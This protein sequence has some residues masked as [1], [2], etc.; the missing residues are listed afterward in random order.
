MRTLGQNGRVKRGVSFCLLGQKASS[1]HSIISS[2]RARFTDMSSDDANNKLESD[3]N[4]CPT[5]SDNEDKNVSS[6]NLIEESNISPQIEHQIMLEPHP[7][8]VSSY[9]IE[10]M[11]RMIFDMMQNLHT[12]TDSNT[13]TAN[14]VEDTYKSQAQPLSNKL[15]VP[16]SKRRSSS[17][18]L[19]VEV[20]NNSMT[21]EG[22][23]DDDVSSSIPLFIDCSNEYLSM[24]DECNDDDDVLSAGH[25]S[26]VHADAGYEVTPVELQQMVNH[27]LSSSPDQFVNHCLQEECRQ[28]HREAKSLEVCTSFSMTPNNDKAMMQSRRQVSDQMTM[29]HRNSYT[30]SPRSNLCLPCSDPNSVA[31]FQEIEPLP[32]RR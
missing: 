26:V 22:D 32:F 25:L 20:N 7:E 1:F 30:T 23:D 21:N 2:T 11:R 31:F 5:T 8:D 24:M 6:R 28:H 4:Y 9:D 18:P 10:T 3:S 19:F 14:S 27:I 13:N 15:L 12:I 16:V 17:I 29:H